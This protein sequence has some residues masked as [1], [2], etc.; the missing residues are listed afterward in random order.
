MTV[1]LM[2]IA[3]EP[4]P[5]KVK[6]RLSP[7]CSPAE[8]ASLAQASLVDTLHAVRD[9]PATRRIC[10]LEGEP[11]HW[12]PSEFDVIPQRGQGLDERLAA[13]FEDVTGPALLVGMDTPQV[14][15]ELLHDAARRLLDSMIDAVFGLTDDGG[16]WIIGLKRSHSELFVGVPMSRSDTG[17]LQ[18]ERLEQAGLRVSHM[19]MLRDVDTIDD[20]AIVADLAPHGSFAHACRELGFLPDAART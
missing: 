16:Y 6:T 18:L 17:A 11:G 1:A 20:A 8:A 10:V 5:G 3:K 12:L 9:T 19:P 2:V 13:A 7:P 14:T 15:P 4:V